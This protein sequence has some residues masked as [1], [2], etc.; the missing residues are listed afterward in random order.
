VELH[1]TGDLDAVAARALAVV[2]THGLVI[3]RGDPAADPVAATEPLVQAFERQ[4]LGVIETHF[5][6]IEDLRP[7]NTTNQNTDQLGYTSAGIDVHTDQPFLP[8][9]PRWQ[10]LQAIVPATHGGDN[11]IVD[12]QAAAAYFASIDE[13]GHA[14]LTSVDVRFHRKQKAFERL[15]VAPI[16][17]LDGPRGFQIRY[18]YFTLAPHRVPFARMRAWYRAYDAFARLVRDPRHQYQFALGRGDFVLYDNLRML[19]GRTAFTGPRW[20][21][22]IYFDEP[23]A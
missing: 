5:G 14:L 17:V 20:L 6:R 4:G 16:V 8:H 21:R 23:A 15:V 3:V 7:D 18:S 9:P 22:G 10:L 13:P 2:R 1:A 12:G 19:H 11:F